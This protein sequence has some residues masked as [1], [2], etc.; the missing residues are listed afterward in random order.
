MEDVLAVFI[1]VLIERKMV[2][3]SSILLVINKNKQQ[4]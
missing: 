1:A 4:I 3:D 2:W